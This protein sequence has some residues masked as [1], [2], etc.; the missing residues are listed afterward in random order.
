MIRL[1]ANEA[2]GGVL[3]EYW[4]IVTDPAHIM[5]ELTIELLFGAVGFFIGRRKWR[6]WLNKHDHEVHGVDD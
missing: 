4:N 1:L 2:S 3:S 6:D 5:A